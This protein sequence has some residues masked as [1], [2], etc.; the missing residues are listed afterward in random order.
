MKESPTKSELF[1]KDIALEKI[2]NLTPSKE[3]LDPILD[4]FIIRVLEE[5][6]GRSNK[7][8]IVKN[9]PYKVKSILVTVYNTSVSNIITNRSDAMIVEGKLVAYGR[10]Y[11]LPNYVEEIERTPLLWPEAARNH[12]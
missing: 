2:I 6:G 9:I 12:F 7:S 8:K 4:A 1:T 5:E 10:H 3:D 11:Q